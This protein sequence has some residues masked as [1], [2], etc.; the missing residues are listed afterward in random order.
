MRCAKHAPGP[1]RARLLA[2]AL[3]VWL[4]ASGCAGTPQ[5]RA[6]LEAPPATLPPAR[7]LA[8]TPFYPQEDY[9]CGPA[10]LATLLTPLGVDTS[11]EAL[12]GE[13]YLPARQGSLQPEM[14]AAIRKRGLL[15]VVLPR[16][17]SAILE[18]I[19]AGHPVLVL[20]NL[21]LDWYPRW[22]YAVVVGYDLD[23]RQLVLRSG[24][25]ER[26]TTA[27]RVFERTW[28]RGDHWAVVAVRPGVVP[29]SADLLAMLRAT[30]DLEET[31]RGAPALT[32]YRAIANRWPDAA[33][34][35]FSLANALMG[36][37]EPQAA[38]AHYLQATAL[39]PDFAPAWNNLAYALQGSGCHGEALLAAD[40]ARRLAPQ[41]ATIAGTLAELRDAPPV[42]GDPACPVIR[43]PLD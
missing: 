27:F 9:Q 42:P 14:L 26:W 41:D 5:T 29:P 39:D 22:H 13:V 17:L 1:S 25:T 20:Q 16:E 38:R 2:G 21:G 12:V 11:P 18:E 8:D 40:C 6:L 23:R 4:L 37:D 34:A 33:L 7:E 31:G 35:Q 3:F 43:C 10:A 32:S 19:D 28:Q 36:T 15:P 24:T 30:A